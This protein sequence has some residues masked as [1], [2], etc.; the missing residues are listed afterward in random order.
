MKKELWMLLVLVFSFFVLAEEPPTFAN[1]QFYGEVSWNKTTTTPSTVV[2]KNG[3]ASFSS[4]IK[5]APC[6]E[7]VCKGR[8]GYELDNI[9]RVKGTNG[10]LL[11]FYVGSQRVLNYTYAEGEATQLNLS[12]IIS[13]VQA[14]AAP[15]PEIKVEKNKTVTNRTTSSNLTQTVLNTT[16]KTCSE[17]WE[18]GGWGIC[19]DSFERRSC[20]RVDDCDVQLAARKITAVTSV[21][22]PVEIRACIVAG[23]SVSPPQVTTPP[24]INQPKVLANCYD[25][26]KN[27]NEEGV[28]C[29][30]VCK[31]C[32]KNSYLLYYILGGL[33]VLL[34]IGGGVYFFW[35][36]KSALGEPEAAELR[37]FY[38]IQESKGESEEEVTEIL[39]EKGW[40][41]KLLKKFLKKR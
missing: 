23:A 38:G 39:K 9:L 20:Y 2:V 26:I 19:T 32:P 16:I 28:D 40:D 31:L 13:S 22:K 12:L 33:V 30:G 36:R 10:D 6:L 18:C 5:A 25:K 41:E 37:S 27:Q 3:A 15:S 34:L 11:Q 35:Q 4:V 8:Y 1:H 21:T 24:I 7:E 17:N 14:A 29:G